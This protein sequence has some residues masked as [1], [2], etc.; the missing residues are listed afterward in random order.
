MAGPTLAHDGDYAVL[1]AFHSLNNFDIP[2]GAAREPEKDEHGN[3]L[4]DYIRM[5]RPN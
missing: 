1:E 4:A 3:S 2:K 5:P